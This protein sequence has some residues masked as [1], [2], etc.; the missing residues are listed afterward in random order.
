VSQ[1]VVIEH[2]ESRRAG[3]LRRNRLR[4]ALGIAAVEGILVLAGVLPWWVVVAA[5]VA[6]VAIYV[7]VAREHPRGDVRQGGWIAAVS[8]LI[9]VLVPVAVVIATVVAV[10]LVVLFAVVIL[11]ALLVDRR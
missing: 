10:A 1:S 11:I 9:V 8:Q 2:R 4:I 6:A 3:S 7:W 5:A